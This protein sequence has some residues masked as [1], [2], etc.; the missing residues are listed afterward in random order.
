[1]DFET[2]LEEKGTEVGGHNSNKNSGGG[3]T[4]GRGWERGKAGHRERGRDPCL[5]HLLPPDVAVLISPALIASIN[6]TAL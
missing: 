6:N 5:A 4:Q 3:E 2:E 1:M